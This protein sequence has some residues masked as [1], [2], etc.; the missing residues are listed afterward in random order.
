V[1]A[2]AHYLEAQGIP[3]T[4]IS[5]IREHTEIIRPP[6]ALW[7]PF[8]LGRPLGAPHDP[9][10]QRRVLVAA[11]KL[12][13]SPKGPVLVEFPDE[14]PGGGAESDPEIAGWSCPVSFAS[15]DSEATDLESLGSAFKRE[16]AELRPW[17]DLSQEKRKRTAVVD[18]D[19]HSAAEL[20]VTFAAGENPKIIKAERS[21]A[22]ALRLA[23]QDLKAFYFEAATAQPGSS[24]PSSGEFNRWFWQE[25]AAAR[26]LRAVKER[27]LNETDKSLRKTGAG[28]L[29]PLDQ[30]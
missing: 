24:S 17:Y 10:F 2:L 11:L 16:V 22:T 19:P 7:V 30:A 1:G 14:A 13:N 5:L 12:L 20:L 25:T 9:E 8:E 18:F 3:T 26:I 29:I 28:L 6:R 4:Q 21:L 27:C 23:T 15:A